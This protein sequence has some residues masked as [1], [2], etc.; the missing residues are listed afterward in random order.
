M[1][2]LYWVKFTTLSFSESVYEKWLETSRYLLVGYKPS[3]LSLTLVNLK[4][5]QIF[6]SKLM[7]MSRMILSFCL[8]FV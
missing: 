2:S 1:R 6:W 7:N 5:K 3:G 4:M 8:I